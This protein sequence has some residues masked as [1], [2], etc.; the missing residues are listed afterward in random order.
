MKSEKYVTKDLYGFLLCENLV[1]RFMKNYIDYLDSQGIDLDENN[2]AFS[3]VDSFNWSKT[4]EG[5][6]FWQNMSIKFDED[7]KD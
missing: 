2:K 3:I 6:Y 4:E 7:F 1:S 5:F